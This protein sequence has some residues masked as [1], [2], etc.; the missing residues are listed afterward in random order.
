M[1]SMLREKY[2]WHTHGNRGDDLCRTFL[3]GR[4]M[5]L[6]FTYSES[7][8]SVLK[9]VINLSPVSMLMESLFQLSRLSCG[10]TI[11]L[12]ELVVFV[13]VSWLRSR[14]QGRCFFKH[15]MTLDFHEDTTR[16]YIKVLISNFTFLPS[17]DPSL[18][19]LLC[20]TPSGPISGFYTNLGGIDG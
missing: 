10:M 6:L 7:S 3:V 12:I 15:G 8:Y 16:I 14:G 18:V 17:F 19:T 2:P 11:L 1:P 13:G 9:E 4:F 5:G 20:S